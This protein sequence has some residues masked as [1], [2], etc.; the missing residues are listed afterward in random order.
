[1]FTRAEFLYGSLA[2]ATAAGVEPRT[3]FHY[4]ETALDRYIAKPTPEYT[5]EVVKTFEGDGYRSQVVSMISQRWRSSAEVDKPLWHHWLTITEPAHV[6]TR[7]G[8]LV[9]S[10]GSNADEPPNKVD[11]VIKQV[12]LQ[13]GAVVAELHMVPNQPLVFA[14]AEKPLGEDDLV[15]YSWDRYLRTGD[16][17]WPLRLPMV[18]AAIRAMD[19]VTALSRRSRHSPV[20]DRFVVGG[21][22][23]RGWTTWLTA[24]ADDRVV[25]IVPVV[26][27]VLNIEPSAEHAYRAYGFW[28][29]ALEAYEKM[30][31]MK[32]LGTPQFDSL[33][34]IEDP[35]SYR[36]RI[37]VPKL[38]VNAAGDQFF[39]PDSSQ[40]YF[41]GLTG[42]KYLRYI[43]NTDHSL[44][45]ASFNAAQ[46]GV[47]FLDSV[48]GN[49]PLPAYDW[50]SAPDGTISVRTNLK[51]LSARLWQAVNPHAR[52]FRLQTIGRAFQSTD[53]RDGGGLLY[54]ARVTPPSRGFA[55]YFI[56][57]TYA[58]M[59]DDVFTVTTGVR[60]TPD[61]LPFGPPSGLISIPSPVRMA[62]RQARVN[63][64]LR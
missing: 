18:K 57:L 22:S 5:Y 3:T 19:T 8:M 20:I 9:I 34:S 32:W 48:I 27:D 10:G 6:K 44:K 46:T 45:G 38:I 51:P 30:G 56:E 13:T 11:G 26:I 4:A 39:A 52:D 63:T 31:I 21:A 55:A 42:R 59:R 35:Y 43:P 14:G 62:R 16:E 28:P 29:E 37:T 7:I 2:A 47:A 36:N 17:T 33:L 64:A 24:A 53:L 58:T 25:A 49:T 61:R 1:M 23:K 54:T 50:Q 15:A 41:G 12:V 40:F 60:V